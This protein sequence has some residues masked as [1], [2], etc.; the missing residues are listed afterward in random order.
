MDNEKYK[1]IGCNLIFKTNCGLWKHNKN[2]HP[3]KEEN[4]NN[5]CKYCDKELSDRKSRWRHE[6]KTCRKNPNLVKEHNTTNIN[7]DNSNDF[8]VIQ[9]QTNNNTTNNITNNITF[10]FNSIGK[11]DVTELTNDEIE[12]IIS[13]GLN[14]ILT[15]IKLLNFNE[16]LPQNHTFC[17]TNL[18]NK[19]INE[20]NIK[21]K[22]IEKKTKIDFF[23]KVLLCSLAHLKK[24]NE[25]IDDCIKQDDFMKKIN[26]IETYIYKPDH[27]KLYI[28]E[29][30][31]LC[32]NNKKH[33]QNTWNKILLGK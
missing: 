4:T 23:D 22:E 15:V 1:C 5:I 30:N 16:N 26:Q 18:N 20:L 32:Y 3:K 28:N 31:A 19:Y 8:N 11:E 2:K 10:N 17:N 27:R 21:T 25:K 13:D 6:N 29:L 24:L 7:I 12:T 33:V 9:N 14:S